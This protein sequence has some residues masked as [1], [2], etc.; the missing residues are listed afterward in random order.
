MARDKILA[1]GEAVQVTHRVST[2]GGDL[3]IR[4]EAAVKTP[5]LV[6]VS[7]GIAEL[8]EG[9]EV[10]VPGHSGLRFGPGAPDGDHRFTW[11]MSWEA[12]FV[13]LQGKR[14]GFLVMSD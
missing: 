13:L 2:E 8:A 11:P 10:L 12:Q 1:A 7:W 14:G 9:V 4:Q 3:I 5:P 6:G